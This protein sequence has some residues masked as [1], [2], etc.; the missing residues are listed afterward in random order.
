[1]A[2]TG[3]TKYTVEQTA[4]MSKAPAK[5]GFDSLIASVA[6]VGNTI[7][8]LVTG[9][10]AA[11]LILY[12]GY[13]LYDTFYTQNQA[14]TSSAELLQYKPENLTELSSGLTPLSGQENLSAINNDYRAW[15][16]VYDSRID[17]P[18]LQGPDD[19]YY[20][21]HDV[22]GNGS[23][24]GAI[25]MAAA[26]SP[27]FS[28]NYNIVYGHHMDNGAMFGELD[29]FR[30]AGY[31]SSH[32]DGI[33]MT[34][35]GI[36]DLKIFAAIDTDAYEA[37]VYTVGNR[38]LAEI[39][40]YIRET[41]IQSDMSAAQG[42][43]KILGLSTCSSRDGTSRLVVF[44]TM[45]PR[46]LRINANGYTGVYD[47]A[48]HTLTVS[49]NYPAGTTFRYSTDGG[50]TWSS[51]KPVIRNAGETTVLIEAT[52]SVYGTNMAQVTLKVTPAPL[53]ITVNNAYKTVGQPDP[54]FTVQVSGLVP[55]DGITHIEPYITIA[56]VGGHEA[57]GM[58]PDVLTASMNALWQASPHAN[59]YAVTIIYGDFTI[60]ARPVMQLVAAGYDGIYDAKP[61][62]VTVQT[63]LLP[64]G[65]NVQYST[66][67]GVT[68]V[69]TPP[70]ITNVGEITVLVR[71]VHAG[72]DTVTATV[73]LR[74]RPAA[75]TVTGDSITKTAGTEDP[76][77]TATVTGVVDGFKI[78]YSVDRRGNGEAPGY[79]ADEIVP[80]GATEQG[81]YIV[82]FVPG[83]LTITEPAKAGTEPPEPSNPMEIFSPKG[84]RFGDRAWA[85]VNL[86]CLILTIYLFVPLLHLK[87]KFG[88]AKLMKKINAAKQELR[89]AD[90]LTE[91]EAKEKERIEKTAF[92]SRDPA[93]P[94]PVTEKEFNS[95][96]EKIYFKVS[97]FL[98]RFRIGLLLELLLSVG[99]L[100]A[101]I[102]TEDMRLPMILIDKWTPLMVLFL[103]ACWG[104]DFGLIRCRDK[105][106]EE[107]E[108]E[109]APE[110]DSAA[111]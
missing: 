37:K 7:V 28:D 30:E 102:L 69:S 78:Q 38:D 82:T 75:V 97:K 72:Y 104:T 1:M 8:S 103:A 87:D 19:V 10:L 68:W 100:I 48:E 20:A 42:A 4:D 91:L 71:A 61:H 18:V 90:G 67:G 70:S 47:G 74:I 34:D 26:S 84:N 53:V 2:E 54:V 35:T 96:V 32:R 50:A 88:R 83:D 56:R 106:G 105:A 111:E 43:S 64:A 21:D 73:V 12:S 31:F 60:T 80:S 55:S 63:N 57:P 110:A 52:N 41:A 92:E 107:D 46:Q 49:A 79:Y 11:F 22:F 99:A 95:A 15:L 9:L 29:R 59:N 93:A 40:D 89:T 16:T 3:R 45:T 17:Y 23:I 98:S 101:F 13:V 36:Y 81:N 94:G 85:L 39:L 66:D 62:P 76:K 14:F 51:V 5:S 33:L 109:K 86:I 6:A 58:Y 24:T 44:A 27:D 77:L 25:Y 108:K 65:T